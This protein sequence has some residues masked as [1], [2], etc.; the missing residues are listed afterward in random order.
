MSWSLLND[1][2]PS[3]VFSLLR[4][5]SNVLVVLELGW[6]LDVKRAYRRDADWYLD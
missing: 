5:Y 3:L 4:I 2:D 6:L 1:A